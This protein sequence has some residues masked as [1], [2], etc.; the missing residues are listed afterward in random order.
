MGSK[1]GG[2]KYKVVFYTGG[3]EATNPEKTEDLYASVQ[4]WG[5]EEEDD[6]TFSTWEGVNAYRD[7]VDPT[8]LSSKFVAVFTEA[9]CLLNYRVE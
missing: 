4:S 8:S 1:R 7:P 9:E 2:G 6:I 3:G 5:T